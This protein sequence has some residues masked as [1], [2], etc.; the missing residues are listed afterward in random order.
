MQVFPG[1]FAQ[2]IILREHVAYFS[3]ADPEALVTTLRVRGLRIVTDFYR[4]CQLWKGIFGTCYQSFR[5]VRGVTVSGSTGSRQRA[6]DLTEQWTVEGH[7]SRPEVHVD[8]NTAIL[9]DYGL[10]YDSY[11]DDTQIYMALSPN[12][13]DLN[14]LNSKAQ[15]FPTDSD[16]DGIAMAMLRLQELY[17]IDPKNMSGLKNTLTL[18]PDE[19]FHIAL[20]AQQSHQVQSAIVWLQETLRKLNEGVNS[21]VTKEDVLELLGFVIF[22]AWNLPMA[23]GIYQPI[24][25]HDLKTFFQL[26]H[27]NSQIESLK[28]LDATH[29]SFPSF[30]I[31]AVELPRHSE[32]DALCRGEGIKMTPQREKRLVCRYTTVG[33]NPMLMYSPAKEEEEWDEPLILRY[34]DLLSKRD[35]EIIKRLSRPKLDRAKV[36]DL[37]TG[38]TTS[39]MV[40]VSSSAWLSEGES[41]VVARANRKI[42]AITGL[43]VETA[44]ELQVA[45]YGI[46]GQFEPHFDTMVGPKI[47][48]QGGRIATV[49]VYMSDVEFGGATVFP[50]IG[51]A[52][53]PK[54]GS[55]VVWFNLLKRGEEDER[56]LHAACP[57]FVGSKWVANKWIH[58][59]GQEFRRKCSLSMLE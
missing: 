44:E 41:P 53:Q 25:P 33:G 59:R 29:H 51:A 5:A 36:S 55:A 16:L 20:V 10:S 9:Q 17:R 14:A 42:A 38:K 8:G 54:R 45:N 27:H 46:G 49:L 15:V 24:P 19:T 40:R 57:V 35:I 28:G 31:S 11:A 12:D 13:S 6:E 50:N 26:A 43:D 39:S 2:K 52:L 3:I 22:Q 21:L 4:E 30:G 58:T 7:R 56:T 32:Y 1:P 18:D 47:M 48:Y 23:L 34:H 37:V